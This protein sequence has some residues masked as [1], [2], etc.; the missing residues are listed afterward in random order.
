VMAKVDYSNQ[1]RIFTGGDPWAEIFFH[2]YWLEP[3]TSSAWREANG[4]P[5]RPGG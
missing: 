2:R 3:I 5:I 1:R 4:I